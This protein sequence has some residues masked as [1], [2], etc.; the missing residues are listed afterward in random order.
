MA[1]LGGA[2]GFHIGIPTA[3]RPHSYLPGGDWRLGTALNH[4][5]IL[6]KGFVFLAVN[7]DMTAV[8]NNP[9]E[10]VYIPCYFENP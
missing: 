10:T 5:P 2:T 1:H 6:C 8:T 7:A 3:G 4:L 9:N